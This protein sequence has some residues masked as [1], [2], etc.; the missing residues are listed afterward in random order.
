MLMCSQTADAAVLGDVTGGWSADMGAYTYFYNT[1]YN[2]SE[3]RQTE[4]YAEYTPNT[5]AVPIVVNGES[6]WGRRDINEAVN[7]MRKN[8]MRPMIGVNA[9]YFSFLTGIPMGHTIIDGEIYSKTN[10]AQ[11]AVG[12]RAD[13]SGFIGRL[14]LKTNVSDGARSIEITFINKWCQAGFDAVYL[15]TDKFGSSTKTESECVFVTCT[16]KE[17]KL[18]IGKELTLTVDDNSVYNGDLAIP[19][20]KM[21]LLA[22]THTNPEQLD[23]LRSLKAGQT[24]KI[25]NEAVGDARW[26]EAESG[27]SSVGGRLLSNGEIGSGF[28]AGSAP[29]T[30]IGIKPDGKIIFY[31]LDGRQSGYSSGARLTT[32]AERMKELGCTDAIN[33]DGGGST[34]ITGVFPGS[35]AAMVVNSPSDGELRRA[36]NYI[37]IKDNRQ[38]T[39]TAWIVNFDVPEAKKYLAGMTVQTSVNSVYD[40]HNYKIEKYGKV[41]YTAENSENGASSVDKNGLVTMAGQ[42][43]VKITAEVDGATADAYF[44]SFETPDE[45]KI[46]NS[47][48]SRE[49]AEIR[50][51]ANEE[52]QLDLTAAAFVNGERIQS[53]DR[54]F[55]WETEG[56]IGEITGEGLFT[57]ADTVNKS[58]KIKVTAGNL[59][60]EIQVII[61]D[62]PKPVNPFADTSGHWAEETISLMAAGGVIR[63]SEENGRIYF[64]PDNDMTR[65]EFAVMMGNFMQ[66]DLSKYSGSNQIFSDRNEIPE[67]ARKSVQAMS[68]AGI[69]QGGENPDG[70]YS[71]NPNDSIT[72][73]EAMTTLGRILS[74]KTEKEIHF[75]DNAEIPSWAVS[76]V[77]SLVS[78]G[79]V[80]GYEDNTIRPNAN[81]TR[82]EAA[83]MLSKL[84]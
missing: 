42:G 41:N 54:L 65:A 24:I 69:I 19:S 77:K 15:I 30:A 33:L 61:A 53:E 11:D 79:I 66:F 23:F 13:G 76:G 27:L 2:S 56:E 70:S 32:L 38:P 22:D 80:T 18:G 72:R 40:T 51:E 49:I 63:G 67:W 31:V 57:L 50:T 8:G 44:E 37:F 47:T 60:K 16:P 48:D 14:D 73:A 12:F 26:N 6:I 55:K 9:D 81:V 1:I 52:L 83:V 25:T 10:E 78:A 34:A 74:S 62:Y 75:A 7:Y 45:I 35:N 5:E 82:A 59:T 4:Y 84:G 46:Y 64:H 17:G 29:R 68:E 20:G 21:I 28:E 71:F 58:G 3:G 39:G 36:A 43:G